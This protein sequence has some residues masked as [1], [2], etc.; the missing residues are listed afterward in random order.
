MLKTTSALTPDQVD[1]AARVVAASIG[2]PSDRVTIVDHNLNPL[3]RQGSSDLVR[4][5]TQDE[6]RRQR[7]IELESKVY[8]TFKIGLVQNANFDTMSV[9]ANLTWILIR[10]KAYQRSIRPDPD[11]QGYRNSY[12]Y[13]KKT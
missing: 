5:S 3:T 7:Q 4:A 1:A 6:M 8:D 12:E 11:G 10:I 13:P 2:V 9:S